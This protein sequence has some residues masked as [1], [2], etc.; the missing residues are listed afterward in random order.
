VFDSLISILKM[1]DLR[2]RI[3]FTLALLAVYRLGIYIPSPGVDRAAMADFFQD[4][5]GTLLSLYNM[6]SGGALQRFSV[7]VLGIMPYISASIIFQIGQ[8]MFPF[9][10]RLKAQGQAGTKKINQYTRYLTILIAIVQSFGISIGLEQMTTMSNQP[11]VLE[12]GW[13]FRFMTVIT[14][15]AGSCFVMWLGEQITERGIGQGASLIITAGIIAGIPSGARNLMQSMNLGQVNLLEIT[16]L[17][18]FMTV[19][20]GLIVFIER[21]QYRVPIQYAKKVVGKQVYGGQ[22][23]HLP[24]KVNVSGVLPPIFASSLMF[25]PATIGQ[26]FPN[27]LFSAIASAFLPG[28]YTYMVTYVVLIVIFTFF[29]TAISF[30]PQDVAD[31]LR[32]QG[33]YIP[34]VRPGKQTQEELDRIL[35]RLTAGGAVYLSAVC[36]LPEILA[37]F[38][39]VPFYFGG[40]GLL[41]IVGVCMQ[42]VAQIEG[43][44]LTQKYDGLSG[45]SKKQTKGRR[46]SFAQRSRFQEEGE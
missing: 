12:T 34:G 14:M 32:R 44:M 2:N 15:T 20:V 26:L 36:I 5:E 6:F 33:G 17:L 16:L 41:I 35:L 40:T 31:N 42:T 38:Y 7:F 37:N 25:F 39:N 11:V 9:I 28:T 19:V 30:N 18:L 29:Y 3:L 21:G 13:D 8:V 24:L 27:D 4:A 43:F 45:P 23:T 1:Q 22:S 46:K 10:E